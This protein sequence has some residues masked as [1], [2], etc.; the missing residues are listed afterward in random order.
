MGVYRIDPNGTVTRLL[1][2]VGHPNGIA[3]APDQRTLYVS[4]A[5]YPTWGGI[6]VLLAYSLGDD[7]SL[8]GR[9]VLVD[10]HG[11]AGFDGITV[12]ADGNIYA[13]CP[14]GADRGVYVFSPEGEELAYLRTPVAPS[15]VAFGKGDH[16]RTLFVTGGGAVHSILT[17][18][19]GYHPGGECN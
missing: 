7:G 10:R 3:V 12:D 13:A 17:S 9:R 1:S 5:E 16:S 2:R 8:S 14:A 18:H 15:N 4:S 19:E 11:S 6:N